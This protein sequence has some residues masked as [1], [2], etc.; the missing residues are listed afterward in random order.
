[1]GPSSSQICACIIV[2]A[3]SRCR[4]S[5]GAGRVPMLVSPGDREQSSVF[6]LH[7]SEPRCTPKPARWSAQMS[8]GGGHPAEMLS[9]QMVRQEPRAGVP[10]QSHEHGSA[11]LVCNF[12]FQQ[13]T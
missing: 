4:A 3:L 8:A 1:M 9:S 11:I 6:A 13:Q 12:I 2:P 5:P 10:L 7:F